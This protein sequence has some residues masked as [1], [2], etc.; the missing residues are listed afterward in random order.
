MADIPFQHSIGRQ[1]HLKVFIFFTRCLHSVN[2]HRQCRHFCKH[3]AAPQ[4]KEIG[5]GILVVYM[6]PMAPF[7]ESSGITGSG[8][9]LSLQ[10]WTS[11]H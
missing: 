5:Q 3:L 1:S 10:L 7:L 6:P 4:A 11:S 8:K 2:F 9:A